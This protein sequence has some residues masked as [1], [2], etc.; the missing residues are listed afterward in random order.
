MLDLVGTL[1][2]AHPTDQSAVFKGLTAIICR[3]IEQGP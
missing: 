1:R 3:A 2:F